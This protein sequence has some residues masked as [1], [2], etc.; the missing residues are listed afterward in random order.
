MKFVKRHRGIALISVLIA[1]T[2]SVMLLGAFLG[3]NQSHMELMRGGRSGDAVQE[4]TES[5][6]SYLKF[7]I[8]HDKTF[9][10]TRFTNDRRNSDPEMAATMRVDE[11]AGESGDEHA[12]LEISVVG[13]DAVVTAEILNNLQGT[14]SRGGVAAAQCRIRLVTNHLSRR[15][16]QEITLQTPPLYDS[17]LASSEGILI[18][19]ESVVFNS[20]DPVRNQVRSSG[21]VRLGTSGSTFDFRRGQNTSAPNQGL[22][23]SQEDILLNGASLRDSNNLADAQNRT[24]GQFVTDA[25]TRLNLHELTMDEVKLGRQSINIDAGHWVFA[26]GVVE[27]NA[28]LAGT[29]TANIPMLQRRTSRLDPSTTE[30]F[31]FLHKDLPGWLNNDSAR[32]VESPG[33]TNHNKGSIGDHYNGFQLEPGL[34]VHLGQGK[35]ELDADRNLE[36]NGDFA[37]FSANPDIDPQVNFVP[38]DNNAN[39][40]GSISV[41]GSLEIEGFVRGSGNLIAEGDVLLRPNSIDTNAD[42]DSDLAIY[43][44][45]NVMIRPPASLLEPARQLNF[46]GLVYAANNF[47]FQA[48]TE[49]FAGSQTLNIEGAL[50]AR[51]G[52]VNIQNAKETNIT[53]NPD[54]LDNLV[55]ELPDNRTHLEVLV[56]KP[57]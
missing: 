41:H 23:W 35:F 44:G 56:W 53:Y 11:M 7:R 37:L 57:R 15:S 36:V 12:T 17:S 27:Y 2:L 3:N 30:D 9:A 45:N 52:H 16:V 46:K 54:Y 26:R 22:V 21:H 51:N 34:K 31:Y 29:R 14:T 32:M 4:A 13:T 8:E 25:Q 5:T 38:S 39:T 6:F 28:G 49:S 55:K 48:H 43:S 20:R 47:T 19:S 10:T 50:I 1:M 24:R 33:A 42:T 18:D 40:R